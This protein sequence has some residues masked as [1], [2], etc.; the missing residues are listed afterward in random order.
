MPRC[1]I[2]RPRSKTTRKGRRNKAKGGGQRGAAAVAGKAG[3]LRVMLR[4]NEDSESFGLGGLTQKQLL[5]KGKESSGSQGSG[6]HFIIG[7]KG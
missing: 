4:H 3:G 1:W 7:G 6:V 2:F 5:Q